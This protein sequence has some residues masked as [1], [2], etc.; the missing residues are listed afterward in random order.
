[1]NQHAI[2]RAHFWKF[3]LIPPGGQKSCVK[4]KTNI[5]TNCT[6]Y[7]SSDAKANKSFSILINI[8]LSFEFLLRVSLKN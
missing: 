6:T 3:H 4:S 1:M 2:V 8:V 5:I 7:V